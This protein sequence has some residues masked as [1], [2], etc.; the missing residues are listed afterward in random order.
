MTVSGPFEILFQDPALVLIHKPAGI[1][2]HPGWAQDDGGVVSALQ[3]Q[4]GT[5]VYPLHR[6]DRGTSGVLALAL[7]PA[8]ARAGALAFAHGA[9]EKIYLAIVRGHPPDHVHVNH[10]LPRQ[11]AA[12]RVPAVTNV[13]RLGV[14]QRYALVKACPQTGRLHQVRRHLKHLSCPVIGDANYGKSEHNRFFR[15]RFGLDR[16]ALAALALRLPHPTTGQPVQAVV[17]PTGSLADCLK[18][19][20][21]WP[22]VLEQVELAFG[23]NR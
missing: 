8:A 3:R 6:L 20:G 14:W 12:E 10:A 2:V 13:Y 18:Q 17:A 21:L 1:V 23:P 11:E 19:M 16:L 7:H 9:V 22:L 5:K 15:E 4:L